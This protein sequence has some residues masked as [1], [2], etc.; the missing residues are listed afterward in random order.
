VPRI[1]L[2][3]SV[4]CHVGTS[5]ILSAD[6]FLPEYKLMLYSGLGERNVSWKQKLRPN[7]AHTRATLPY[8]LQATLTANPVPSLGRSRTHAP[9]Q[10]RGI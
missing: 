6:Y 2:A 9:S 3:M 8:P 5:N 10:R 4:Q 7:H 1:Q